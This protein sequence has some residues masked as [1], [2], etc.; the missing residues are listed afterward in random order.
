MQLLKHGDALLSL[1]AGEMV[2]AGQRLVVIANGPVGSSILIQIVQ[3]LWFPFDVV[4]QIRAV[5][6]KGVPRRLPTIW[7]R[8]ARRSPVQRMLGRPRRGGRSCFFFRLFGL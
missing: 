4:A 7:G 3:C 2:R 5:L 1:L 8:P 6:G